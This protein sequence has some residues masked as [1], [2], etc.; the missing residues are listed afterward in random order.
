MDLEPIIVKIIDKNEGLEWSLEY[1]KFI[2]VE[3]RKFLFLCLE[4]KEAPI[5][6]PTDVDKFGI[7]IS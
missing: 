4:N 2:E 7:I 3:Y 5:V 6:P 1:V